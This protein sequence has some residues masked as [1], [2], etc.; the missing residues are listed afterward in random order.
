MEE[1]V[2]ELNYMIQDAAEVGDMEKIT[3]L[4]NKGALA[5]YG[6]EGA[7]STGNIDLMIFF[8][9]KGADP[10]RGFFGAFKCGEVE[11]MKLLIEKGADVDHVLSTYGSLVAPFL[12]KDLKQQGITWQSKK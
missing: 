2:I 1:S 11:A 9:E 8:L 7:A 3:V 4:L 5:G 12:R 6:L 10:T